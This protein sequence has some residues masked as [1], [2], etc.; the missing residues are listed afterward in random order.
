MKKNYGEKINTIGNGHGNA[1]TFT[2][3]EEQ[4]PST[5]ILVQ[6]NNDSAELNG[7]LGDNILYFELHD[8]F[9]NFHNIG[10]DHGIGINSID[11]ND[12]HGN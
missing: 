9:D 6:R 12:Y 11:N 10:L 5:T 7:D 4:R 8:V 3:A 2:G 1:R